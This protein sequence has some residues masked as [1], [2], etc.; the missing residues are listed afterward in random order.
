MEQAPH[1]HELNL[2]NS[3]ILAAVARSSIRPLRNTGKGV[4]WLIAGAK[5]AH[6]V[7]AHL[8][9]STSQPPSFVATMHVYYTSEPQLVHS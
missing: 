3:T 9:L 4:C 5:S 8:G 7:K 6:L 1:N 2:T